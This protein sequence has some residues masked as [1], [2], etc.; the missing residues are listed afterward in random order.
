[1]IETMASARRL[2]K[3]EATIAK[4][5]EAAVA[6]FESRSY[7]EVTMNLIAEAARVTKGALYHHFTSKEELYLAMMHADLERK[8]R[9]FAE[10][11]S[12]GD[13]CREK[14][15]HLTQ[16][17]FSLSPHEQSLMKLVRRDV[18]IFA[19]PERTKLIRAY[20]AT[21][22]EQVEQA[23]RTG[24]E[25]GELAPADPRLLAWHFVALVEVV[26]A[27]YADAVFSDRE[28]KLDYVINLFFSGAAAGTR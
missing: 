19:E 17:F 1:M 6:L 4:I 2:P 27:A 21:L 11:L 9:Q 8:K 5:L 18:N 14:L 12:V 10:A 16:L 15:S 25:T 7:A 23:L 13:T 22:P 20:Q 3:S 26:L 24:I 28:A